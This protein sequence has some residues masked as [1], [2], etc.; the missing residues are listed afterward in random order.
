MRYS[1]VGRL[2]RDLFAP[3][4]VRPTIPG[5][6]APERRPRPNGEGDAGKVEHKTGDSNERLCGLMGV[7]RPVD[8]RIEQKTKQCLSTA[9]GGLRNARSGTLDARLLVLK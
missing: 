4:R 9:E 1:G 3:A 7:F 5:P 8:G 6:V 2:H